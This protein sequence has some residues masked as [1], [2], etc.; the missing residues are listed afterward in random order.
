MPRS[1]LNLFCA[2]NQADA[3]L[4]QELLTHLAIWKRKD[5]ISIWSHDQIQTGRDADREII[6]HLDQA[7]LVLLLLSA[8][9]LASDEFDLVITR[10]LELQKA[11]KARVIP[12]LL[13][14]VDLTDTLLAPLKVLPTDK[15][16]VIN[17][18]QT[19]NAFVD[20]QQGIQRVMAEFNP[21]SP[22]SRDVID[23][24]EQGKEAKLRE[25]WT[26]QHDF[27]R[28]RV[29]RFV[30]RQV[31]LTV[32][33]KRIDEK[34]QHGGYVLITGD[35]GQGKSSIIAKMI[36]DQGMDTVAYHFIPFGPGL[37]HKISIVRKL[38]ARLILKYDLPERYI[39]GESYGITCDYF[40]RALT[41][42]SQ[43]GMQET[44]Y[45]DGLDQ[46]ETGSSGVL[47]LSFLPSQLPPGIVIVV[48]T[49]PN[50]T[51]QQVQNRV[52]TEDFYELKGLR[53]E[54]FDL[55]LNHRG[56]FLSATVSDSLYLKLKQNALYLDLVAQEL[57]AQPGLRPEDLIA[58]L[59]NNPDNIFTI[60]FTRMRGLPEWGTVIRPTLGLLLV[61]QEP[62]TSLQI[63]HVLKIESVSVRTGITY[64]GGLLT[65]SGYLSYTLFHP[66]LSEYLKQDVPDNAIQFDA[67]EVEIQHGKLADW[68]EQ[69]SME[70]I[71]REMP[72]P[73]SRDDYQEYAQKHYITHLYKAR[74]DETLFTVLNDGDYE[75]GK[76]RF[77]RSTRATAA[78]LMLGCE[79]AAREAGTLNDGKARLRNLWWYTLLRT[80]LTTQAD[81]YPIEAFQ[82]L[83]AL[84]KE[85]QALDQAELLTQPA[86]KLAVLILLT[87]YLLKQPARQAEGIQLYLRVYEIA[88]SVKD[89]NIQ[90]KALSDLTTA[91]IKVVHLHRAA[92]VARS[93]PDSRKRAEAFYDVSDAYGE[94]N[95]WQKAEEVARAVTEDEVR[96]RA[97]SNL[98]AKLKRADEEEK[99][100]ALWREAS[101]V[102]LSIGG[103]EQHD[104]AIYYLSISFMQAKEW[105]RAE[106]TVSMIKTNEE[107][108][109]ALCQL[110]QSF[111]REGL[112]TRAEIAWEEA[113]TMAGDTT[114]ADGRRDKAYRIYA[115][116]Q[117]RCGFWD[118]V[119]KT[120]ERR[121]DLST[122]RIVVY[123]SLA[124]N[125]IKEGLWDRSRRTID[126]IV[127][128]YD[129]IDVAYPL[130]DTI[131]IG[132]SIDLAREAQWEQATKTARSIP[133][134]EAQCRA[135]MAIVN[136]M[137]QAG[138][139]ESA[140]ERW[141]K[142]RVMCT[143]QKDEV[144]A[145]V[146]GILAAVLVEIGQ[147]EQAQKIV[148]T[149]PDKQTQ[150][151]MMERIAITLARVG[152][153]V[154]AEKIASET[155]N[156]KRNANIQQSI[157]LAQI[158]AGE[159]TQAIATANLIPQEKQQSF[160]LSELVAICCQMQEWD[161]AQDIAYH[162]RAS[163]WQIQA[164]SYI[165]VELVRAGKTTEAERLAGSISNPFYKAN[166]M[167]DLATALARTG[168]YKKADKIAKSI[169]N[170]RIQ[171]KALSN[172]SMVSLLGASLAE[173]VAR[174]IVAGDEREE[175]LYNVAIAYVNENAWDE[176]GK[177]AEDISDA[178]KRDT[179]WGTLAREYAKGEQWPQAIGVFDKIQER[180]K[181]I[182]VLQT[183]GELLIKKASK[184]VKE[185]IVQ[186]IS[187][188]EE[189]AS[190]FVSM[191]DTLAEA[192][193]YLEQVRFTQQ[194]WLQASTKDDCEYLFAMV[195]KLL[196]QHPEMC[197][198]F[199]KSF[200]W[201]DTFLTE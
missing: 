110:A 155:A 77:D 156:T 65:L 184:E 37:D 144:Q 119:E 28:D 147:V 96:V 19:D 83:L 71:W 91:L 163:D 49:R 134:K 62:L 188:R 153:I 157:A 149:L 108:V 64:L 45:I 118:E 164:I 143:A 159:S 59:A 78:D 101:A 104:R 114:K 17:W 81:A 107:R 111:M 5:I 187:N 148:P 183:W 152:K 73:S 128:E 169:K 84:G 195:R 29:K 12:I 117:A 39:P 138:L 105:Q 130:L 25:M 41:D 161:L 137:A 103:T 142:A 182:E 20:I 10:A 200:G 27:V 174:A 26:D 33:R 43:K 125:M 201:V 162:I 154:E 18:P 135:L 11:G 35:A 193:L 24:D 100:E 175:A 172:I 166:I 173:T 160:V 198:G 31:E 112:D 47:D 6:E 189:K 178:Q 165:T 22:K 4:Q 72:N 139:R 68:C 48:G 170:P 115:I 197:D 95:D 102:A 63:A 191:A 94:Q 151:N 3:E 99:A 8:D 158:N 58:R 171:E 21:S 136:V 55:L 74:R 85:S 61:A 88:T 126:L 90:T 185:R 86:R 57:L 80:S 92:D 145:R 109:S 98:A 124:A 76:L 167:C 141:E 70:E 106:T 132:L 23:G 190:L 93:I 7:D 199:Y 168:Y 150:E 121:I 15:R 123:D 1:P 52:T 131:L 122:E 89:N 82:A 54:D 120:A 176:A 127:R 192:S 42:I 32:L 79:A 146:T 40:L 196:L 53:R 177:I 38:L 87:E 186:Y 44:I 69:G 179:V 180:K 116:A 181:R 75:R 9:F 113:Q 194:A 2:Y 34:M 46:L 36:A 56:I 14:P 97:L 13:R 16:A 140:Q 60:T 67:E 66:K 133:R 51:L 30:G 50:H 129:L